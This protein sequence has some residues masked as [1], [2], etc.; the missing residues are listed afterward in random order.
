MKL[1][2]IIV[3]GANVAGFKAT[4]T[5]RQKGFDGEILLVGA[6]PHLPYDRPPL[7]KQILSG[8]L[9][10][11]A[12]AYRDLPWFVDNRIEL[13]LGM[14]ATD[15]DADAR[16]LT[17]GNDDIR[18][19]GLVIATGARAREFPMG[20]PLAGVH[21]LRTLDDALKLKDELKP[22]AS[23]VVIG[24]GFIGAEVASSALS[25]G[26]KVTILEAASAPLTRVLGVRL[27]RTFGEIHAQNGVKLICSAQ[28]NGLRGTERVKSVMLGDGT[29]IPA[30]V[31]VVGIGAVPNIE[32]LANSG[33]EV[34]NGLVCDATLNT[35]HASIYGA[36]DV[37]RW[38]NAWSGTTMRSEQWTIAADQ[39]RHAAINLLAGRNGAT[40]FTT[41]PYF[42]S[43]QYGMRI[44]SMGR[45]DSEVVMLTGS[46]D[47]RPFIGVYRDKHRLVGVVTVNAPKAFAILRNKMS[48]NASFEDA[49]RSVERFT[50][51][52]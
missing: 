25:M 27:G 4:E 5:L 16:R 32:W 43:D 45:T 9:A 1:K 29:E 44:Q 17:I 36:G 12:P 50:V 41:I 49:V 28:V 23:V 21:T 7:S 26:A 51:S 40:P 2:R 22:G 15:L 13:L 3:V 42:W 24:A 38:P 48:E 14:Q 37:A 39:G 19:D 46:P 47:A 11:A 6:E 20:R 52:A 30:D 18:F 10:P 35:R 33:L 34:S 8:E 31:V